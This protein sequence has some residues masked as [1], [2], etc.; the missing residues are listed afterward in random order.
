[1][2]DKIIEIEEP[3]KRT[4]RTKKPVEIPTKLSSQSSFFP[5]PGSVD[6][7]PWS[8]TGIDKMEDIDVDNFRDVTSM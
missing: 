4:T 8:Q 1:M 5:V 2:T 3:K 6:M 7:N